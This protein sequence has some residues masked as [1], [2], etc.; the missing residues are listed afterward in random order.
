[1]DMQSTPATIAIV[2]AS[3]LFVTPVVAQEWA[4]FRGKSGQGVADA[5]DLPATFTDQNIHWRV[6]TGGT[7]HSSPVLWDSRLFFTRM[8]KNDRSREVVCFDAETG[9]ESWAFTCTFDPHRQHRFNSFASS[10]PAV[11]AHGVYV[12]WSSGGKLFALAVSHKGKKLWRRELGLF[13]AQHGSGASPILYD[14]NLVIA[15]QNEGEESFLTALH[16]ETGKTQWRIERRSTDR[17]ASYSCPVLYE[18]KGMDPLILF[19]SQPYGLTAVEPKSGKIAWECDVEFQS[20][21]VAT[22]CL[23]GTSAFLSSGSGGGGKESAFVTLPVKRGDRPEVH[24]RMR[25][26]IP[27]VP[28]ALALGDRVFTFSDGGV[29]SC[30]KGSDGSVVWRERMDGGFF[31]SP[32]SNGRTI[33]I[34]TK[35]GTLLSIGS[36]ENYEALGSY[37]LGGPTYSTPAIAGNKLFVRT[38]TELIALGARR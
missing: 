9:K 31:S 29:A 20:R 19:A 38:D 2:L 24:S 18:H 36:G 8:G 13:K 5:P 4:Q 14:D 6:P 16:T 26:A 25:R 3:S 23:I 28:C 37:N 33:Y 17:T 7:G 12:L 1:M 27:Y 22:P 15:N 11:D 30:L 32:V 34:P 10:T 35:D 21:C